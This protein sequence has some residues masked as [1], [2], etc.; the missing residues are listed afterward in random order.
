MV[1]SRLGSPITLYTTTAV[2]DGTG[3]A[4]VAAWASATYHPDGAWLLVTNA[5]ASPCEIGSL[6]APA[7]LLT[8]GVPAWVLFE[9]RIVT[10]DPG[11]A[12][13]ARVP[14]ALTVLGDAWS[15][16]AV[17]TSSSTVALTIAAYPVE[18][19]AGTPAEIAGAVWDE[20]LAGHA[21]GGTAGATI[22]AGATA[23]ALS[24]V[25]A[26][27]SALPTAAAIATA[28]LGATLEG[29]HTVAGGIRLLLSEALGKRT[30]SGTSY[31]HRD[32]ADSKNRIVGTVDSS[33]NR[34][35]SS[36][37]GT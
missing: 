15:V 11:E 7:M 21:T 13:W 16:S 8:D 35:T 36:A 31:T 19:S 3:G 24:A 5:G 32:L 12:I 34:T 23:S 9:G 14:A 22:A 20:V 2:L 37:D 6:S 29:A 1:G 26:L 10:I 18:T 27:V 25:A 28:V 4:S 30:V 33:G 17:L